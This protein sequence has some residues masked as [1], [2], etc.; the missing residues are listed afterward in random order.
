MRAQ[1]GDKLLVPGHHTGEHERHGE[2]IEVHGR[3][4]A[5][6][7]VVRWSDTGHDALVFPGPDATIG[8][9]DRGHVTTPSRQ[10]EVRA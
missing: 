5:P 7:Y 1:V 10:T 6:P 3:D 9:F 2:I 4:G 8:H